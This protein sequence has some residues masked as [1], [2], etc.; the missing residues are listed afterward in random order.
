[1]DGLC[2]KRCAPAGT[3]APSAAAPSPTQRAAVSI[4]SQQRKGLGVPLAA[5][6]GTLHSL[7]LRPTLRRLAP[8]APC[9]SCATSPR[10]TPAA[11]PGSSSGLHHDFHDNLYVLL[12]GSKRFRLFPPSSAPDMYVAGR[13]TKVH[14][15]GR[16]VYEGQGDVLPD[17][18][19]EWTRTRACCGHQQGSATVPAVAQPF[20]LSPLGTPS[21]ASVSRAD[22]SWAPVLLP[23]YC[24][25]LPH[26]RA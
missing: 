9:A 13:I 24:A 10:R 14:A 26:R 7:A 17:G 2:A 18:S 5:Q 25:L 1:M 21:T 22:S 12:R 6:V 23:S 15:N 16:I 8:P 4:R 19:S 20:C 11:P 3:L